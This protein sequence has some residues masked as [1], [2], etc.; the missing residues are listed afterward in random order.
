LLQRFLLGEPGAFP[1]WTLFG[2]C[3]YDRALQR[4]GGARGD[5]VLSLRF[6]L[7]DVFAHFLRV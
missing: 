1:S 6:L 2:S 7:A 3:R 4:R 5:R